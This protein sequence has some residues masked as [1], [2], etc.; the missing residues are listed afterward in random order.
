MSTTDSTDERVEYS[1]DDPTGIARCGP[2]DGETEPYTVHGV[3]IGED[4]V[5]YGENGAKFWPEEALRQAASTLV[6]VPLN[7][8]HDDDRVEA[9]IGEVVDVG[10]EDGVGVVFEAV[11]D[12]EEIATQITR[13]RLEVSIHALHSFNGVTDDGEQIVDNARF[14][15]L[16]VVPRGAAP[17]NYVEAG[18]SD[19]LAALSAT[20]VAQM[21]DAEQ[22]G[23]DPEGDD[24]PDGDDGQ[25]TSA[26][27]DAR[28]KD[29]TMT[30]DDTEVTEEASEP[31]LQDEE[32]SEVEAS[33]DDTE[34]SEPETQETE[35]REQIEELETENARLNDELESVRME[36]AG[37]LADSSP[38]EATELT[39]KFTFDEL[40]EKFDES[41]LELAEE[42]ADEESTPAPQTGNAESEEE[43]STSPDEHADEISKLEDKVATY[44]DLEWDAARRE[45]EE[46][47]SDLQE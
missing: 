17:G 43:L 1:T 46:R 13:G 27:S 22:D 26:A 45:A 34:S 21:L 9:V 37:R 6:G 35:L 42:D 15:D 32:A 28:D 38:F 39:E 29:S 24:A 41:E 16:S 25:S 40:Q 31:E 18:E 10:Y 3:A 23:A 8:N 4:D 47:L 36:Y 33:E 5:T 12:D 20:D 19:A 2:L 30:E 7:K 11:V 14:L 44:D